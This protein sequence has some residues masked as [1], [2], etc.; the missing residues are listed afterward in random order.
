[1]FK[2]LMTGFTAAALLASCA[3]PIPG[4]E[5]TPR[6]EATRSSIDAT[7]DEA[8]LPPVTP[9]GVEEA[10]VPEGGVDYRDPAADD[11]RFDV[12][13]DEAPARAFFM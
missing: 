10:L 6:G 8:S 7:L 13:T 5:A 1:M 3:I 2:K 12:N 11:G 4:E 9:T